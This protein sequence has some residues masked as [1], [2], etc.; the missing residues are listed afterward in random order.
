ML[1]CFRGIRALIYKRE[2]KYLRQ[3]VSWLEDEIHRNF[4]IQCKDVPTGSSLKSEAGDFTE[5][6]TPSPGTISPSTQSHDQ[7]SSTPAGDAADIGMLALNATGEMKYLGPSSGAFFAAYASALARSCLS[8][9]NSENISLNSQQGETDREMVHRSA[10]KPSS[11]SS[12]DINLFLISYKMWILPL[13]PVLNSDDLDLLIRTYAEETGEHDSQM[14]QG[15][16]E[17]N[18]QLM[19]FYMVMALGAVNAA[20]TSQQV[21]KQSRH[22]DLLSFEASR[23][24][25][26]SLCTRALQLIDY[27]SHILHPSVGLIQVF[28]L[29]A[30]Y[31]SYGPIG[32]SQWELAGF[33]MRVL[34]S[35]TFLFQSYSVLLLTLCRW[36]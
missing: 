31:S 9:K 8:T 14:R 10:D 15:G 13:Y 7:G 18:I 24:S 33:A 36:L 20:N 12:D 3:R 2:L 1:V 19:V 22:K 35:L 28:V 30:I 29:I 25:P 26:I 32:S 11:L 16:S 5:R 23:P 6:P 27:N 4:R 21:R 34:L 17:K